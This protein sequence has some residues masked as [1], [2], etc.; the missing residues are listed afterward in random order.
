MRAGRLRFTCTVQEPAKTRGA[1][2]EELIS[3]TTVVIRPCSLKTGKGAERPVAGIEVEAVA[4]WVVGLRYE[5]ALADMS[6]EWQ[7][8]IDGETYLITAV[9][10]VGGMNKELRV[11]C[12]Q[13]G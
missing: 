2:G 12:T 7:L 4:P 13:H 1:N 9:E 5:N 6:A 11:Y 10:N 8:E 3:W